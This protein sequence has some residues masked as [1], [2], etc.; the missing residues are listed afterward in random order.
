MKLFTYS[1]I[2][3]VFSIES[4][5]QTPEAALLRELKCNTPEEVYLL[6][7]LHRNIDD[8]P[9]LNGSVECIDIDEDY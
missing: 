7:Y 1:L 2:P 9:T 5:E 8:Y 3:L 6:D 4:D